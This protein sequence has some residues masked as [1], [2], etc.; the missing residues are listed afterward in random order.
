MAKISFERFESAFTIRN[1]MNGFAT[2]EHVV[3]V[4][5]DPLLGDTSIYN[6]YLKDKA[7][8]FFGKNDEEL[9][10]KLVDDSAA[11]CLFCGENARTR[12]ACYADDLLPGGR[13][14]QGEAVLFANLFSLAQHHP[15]IVL[16]KQ[17]FLRPSEFRPQLLGDGF[18]AARMF[19]NE[20]YERDATLSFATVNCNYLPPAGASLVHPHLQMLAT[21]VPYSYHARLLSGSTEYLMRNGTYYYADLLDEEQKLGERYIAHLGAWHWLA[22]FSPMGSNEIM[23]VHDTEGD[24]GRITVG[25]LRDLC[26]GISR[27]LAFYERRGHLSFNFSLYSARGGETIGIRCIFKIV[28]RQNLYPNYR[29]DDYFLQKMLQ[30]ELIITLP[31]DLAKE[32]RAFF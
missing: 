13:L 30:S 31:E 24:M 10:K 22:A 25:D 20:L 14:E 19:L 8:A 1:P 28:T 6:P 4:R 9:L 11:S 21:H 18:H 29:N 23:A 17:H 26:E 2:E 3:E 7:A 5:K 12:T 16:S 15:V 27:V 32:A